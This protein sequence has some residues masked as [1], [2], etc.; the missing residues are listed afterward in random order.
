MINSSFFKTKILRQP[1]FP[2]NRLLKIPAKKEDLDSF[3]DSLYQ[4]KLFM[5]AV[6]LSSPE[7]VQ[8]FEKVINGKDRGLINLS[9]LKFYA[10]SFSNTVPFGLF[11]T[12]SVLD[13]DI[14]NNIDCQNQ[15]ERMSDIDSDYFSKLL[16]KLNGHPGIKKI[17]KFRKNNTLYKIGL[18]Y[19]YIEPSII[20]NKLNYTLSSIE[21]NELIELL[22]ELNQSELS[23][24][25]LSNIII[26]NVEDVDRDTAESF[27][28]EMVNSKIFL[29]SLEFTLNGK[30]LLSQV[31]DF[32]KTN[33]EPVQSDPYLKSVY[34]VLSEL[35]MLIS[36][37]DKNIFN[38]RKSYFKI[39]DEIAK[40]GIEFDKKLIIN[41]NLKIK[42][43]NA[44]DENNKLA[45]LMEALNLVSPSPKYTRN[46]NLKK[47][48]ER[49]YRRYEDSSAPLLEVLDNELGIGYIPEYEEHFVFS[50]LIDNVEL[51]ANEILEH[52]I[53][54]QPKIYNFWMNQLRTGKNE[55]DL[56]TCDLTCF[57]REC[58]SFGT[59]SVSFSISNGKIFL[60]TAGGSSASKLL[61]RFSPRDKEIEAIINELSDVEKK[62]FT[63]QISAEVIHLP[64]NRIANVLIRNIRREAELSIISRN[65]H[66]VENIS[67]NDLTISV[68]KD[69]VILRSAKS[70][71]EIIP[72]M[73]SAQNYHFDSLPIY[74]FLCD[75]QGQ[76]LHNYFGLNFGGLNIHALDFI[77]RI[78]FGPDIILRKATWRISRD[79]IIKGIDKKKK[80]TLDDVKKY[81]NTLR[82]PRFVYL[83]ELDEEK[84]IIDVENENLLEIFVNEVNK[85]SVVEL[86]ECIYPI[87]EEPEYANEYIYS[88]I[89]GNYNK[90]NVTAKNEANGLKRKFVLGDEWIYFK[91][92]TG[93][94]TANEILLNNIHYLVNTLKDK[95]IID[96]WFFIRF[97]DPEFHIR[98]RFHIIDINDISYVIDEINKQANILLEEK[99][100]WK[101]D[102]S[103]YDRELERYLWN[104]IK[105]SET[106]FHYDS[107]LCLSLLCHLKETNQPE[108]VWIYIIRSIDEYFNSFSI[109]LI[110]RLAVISR[111]F[112]SFWIEFGSDKKIKLQID[113]KYRLYYTEITKVLNKSYEVIDGIF[114]ERKVH[115]ANISFE[116][117]KSEHVENLL[118]SY[119]HMNINR[120]INANPRFH[121][122]LIYGLLQKQYKQQIAR[123]THSPGGKEITDEVET[124]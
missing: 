103:P 9:I 98:V 29:S 15:Y 6:F 67:L 22:L 75:L 91:M 69:K 117:Y 46:E 71:K 11:A 118:R 65:S 73:T 120:L 55:V 5:E 47:F 63:D 96:K 82:L 48:S 115:I 14:P 106:L 2:L 18:K 92:Y 97:N 59:Y 28:D 109:D 35:E 7:L 93:R 50:D 8:E 41:S 112:D 64:N 57:K 10:R 17:V 114:H 20:N 90:R 80:V 122:L 16:S 1:L 107:E 54:I 86:V 77:P 76:Y 78:C 84:M 113:K 36:E 61:S 108:K 4:D 83:S 116:I 23:F 124:H 66:G 79:H 43:Q 19:R 60:K 99:K 89:S 24:D 21:H 104:N 121:E 39:Y 33:F 100:I 40:I 3:I 34:D 37:L 13:T 56:Q 49:F 12:Y 53:T 68:E 45:Q 30:P 52:Q 88:G 27:I 105:N 38:D 70:G 42:M 62:Y 31:L 95:L 94:V 44:P 85:K 87:T 51:P 111:M 25:E 58:S 123:L 110:T 102:F 81:L 26:E 32:F 119:I 101:I 72:F 74:Q